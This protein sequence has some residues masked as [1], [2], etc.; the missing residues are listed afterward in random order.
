M[1]DDHRRPRLPWPRSGLVPAGKVGRGHLIVRSARNPTGT[2]RA[3]TPAAAMASDTGRPS[4]TRPTAARVGA[5]SPS[6]GP[7]ATPWHPTRD[8][9]PASTATAPTTRQPRLPGRPIAAAENPTRRRR[10]LRPRAR[11]TWT[12]R[13][14][15]HRT[16]T[17]RTWTRGTRTR[18]CRVPRW[19]TLP[20]PGIGA[21]RAVHNPRP[22]EPVPTSGRDPPQGVW[23]R[24]AVHIHLRSERR[25]LEVTG[26]SRCP[27]GGGGRSQ[28]TGRRGRGRR[29]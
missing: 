11:G 27:S 21:R 3:S 14:W 4:P 17:R 24:A 19:G 1:P 23:V 22:G 8:R 26:R 5:A 25:W 9:H 12:H 6:R 29:R 15:T 7:P 10:V 2:T 16:W 13:T 28:S 18:R 20:P